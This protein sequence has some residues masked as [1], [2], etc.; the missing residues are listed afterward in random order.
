MTSLPPSQMQKISLKTF[1]PPGQPQMTSFPP[2]QMQKTSGQPQMTSLPPS[3]PQMTSLPPDQPQKISLKTSLPPGQPQMTSLP[4]GQPYCLQQTF[5]H[6]SQ[7]VCWTST[8]YNIRV[9][10]KVLPPGAAESTDYAVD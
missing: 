4:P 10:T 8:L 5:L 7:E 2:N 3:Q 9:I 6:K 1:L